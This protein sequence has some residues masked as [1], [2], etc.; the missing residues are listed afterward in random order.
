MVHSLGQALLKLGS[1]GVPDIYQGSELWDLN[2]VDPDNRRAVDFERRATLLAGLKGR[3][4]GGEDR[5]ALASSILAEPDDGA[6]KLYLIWTALTHRR[7]QPDIYRRG[8]YVPLTAEGPHAGRIVAFARRREGR[9]VV[10]IAAQAGGGDDGRRP[11][12]DV[13]PGRG[14]GDDE[15]DP[16]RRPR[17]GLDRPA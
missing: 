9:S 11:L 16:A 1:P 5:T 4:D 10:V 3:L 7:E 8:D 12:A 17:H 6:I 13:P 15:P 2:L 14:V